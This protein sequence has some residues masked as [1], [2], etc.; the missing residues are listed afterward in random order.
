MDG[1]NLIDT[2]IFAGGFGSGKSEVALNFALEKAKTSNSTILAD[3]DLVNPY[4][5]SRELRI[6][7]EKEGIR[8]LSPQGDL[9]FGDVP[10]L[11]SEI[12]GLIRQDNVMFID[13]AGDEVGAL[14]LGYLSQYLMR[15]N[16]ELFLVLN[17]YRPFANELHDLQEL[18]DYL[19]RAAQLKFTGII[20]NPNLVE[21]TD[22]EVIIKGH[23]RVVEFG[24]ALDI[25]VKHIVVAI[26]SEK[27]NSI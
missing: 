2:I 10:N 7:L 5:A 6:E 11:P 9:S 15:R 1:I 8:L 25:P 3:L 21:E 26:Y 20:S 18:R 14:V 12:I 24:N 17:P 22:T 19:Q 16:Y 4:F 27:L 23:Q 13:L